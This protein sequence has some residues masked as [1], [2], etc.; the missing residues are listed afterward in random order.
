M[1]ALP[2]HLAH[3]CLLR[4]NRGVVL[5]ARAANT[6]FKKA[7]L[8]AKLAQR[9]VLALLEPQPPLLVAWEC[10][11]L[12]ELRAA[13]TAPL[14]DMRSSRNRR[15]APRVQRGATQR[16]CA[17]LSAHSAAGGA[18]ARVEAS[19][20]PIAALPFTTQLREGPAW[21]AL[22]GSTSSRRG[23]SLVIRPAR[24]LE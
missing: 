19:R 2:A 21:R 18:R 3:T 11:R 12:P 23:A 1:A 6:R 8:L 22:P 5:I 17:P 7:R 16:V 20:A 4:A 9:G 15:L 13:P 10:M 14:A 24:L